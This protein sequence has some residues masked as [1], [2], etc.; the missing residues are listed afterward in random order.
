MRA[1]IVKHGPE[2]PAKHGKVNITK[3]QDRRPGTTK[4]DEI[5]CIMNNQ[6]TIALRCLTSAE[7]KGATKP[8]MKKVTKVRKAV[9]TYPSARAAS[10]YMFR[11]V[12][13]IN[14]TDQD[15]PA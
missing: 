13:E 2:L 6:L 9:G 11:L 10:K 12:T 4:D 5:K 3:D 14:I 7:I 8:S 1:I 15:T